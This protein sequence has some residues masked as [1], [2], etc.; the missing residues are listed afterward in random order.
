MSQPG[1]NL[2]DFLKELETRSVAECLASYREAKAR[3]E[4][5]RRAGFAA[6]GLPP[7]LSCPASL[8][9]HLE[10]RYSEETEL[11]LSGAEGTALARTLDYK[12]YPGAASPPCSAPRPAGAGR[13]AWRGDWRPPN[14]TTSLPRRRSAWTN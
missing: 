6:L 11:P 13:A 1:P 7:G 3:A 5:D 4:E 14:P 8:L 2:L 12:R 10:S 9:Y